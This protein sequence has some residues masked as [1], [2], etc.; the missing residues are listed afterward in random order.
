LGIERIWRGMRR[1]CI[2][3]DDASALFLPLCQAIISVRALEGCRGF[4]SDYIDS[5]VSVITSSRLI[6]SSESSHFTM[7]SNEVESASSQRVP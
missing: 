6:E 7:K 4:R 5:Q 1:G 3:D 2:G